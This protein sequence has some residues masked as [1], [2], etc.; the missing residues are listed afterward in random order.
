MLRNKELSAISLNLLHAMSGA[1]FN[2]QVI[3]CDV[4]IRDG[5]VVPSNTDSIQLS[6]DDVEL[7]YQEFAWIFEEKGTAQ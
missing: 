6:N 1:S 5:H 3:G 7:L 2:S 4:A